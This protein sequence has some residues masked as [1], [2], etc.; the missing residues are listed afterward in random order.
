MP[1]FTQ[2]LLPA[3]LLIKAISQLQNQV[4]DKGQQIQKV[5]NHRQI[6]LPVAVVVFQF[7]A[8]ILIAVYKCVRP[9]I[10]GQVPNLPYY[11][12][13]EQVENLL[14]VARN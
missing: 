3:A 14:H 1:G 13:M 2:C 5:K 9:P 4:T 8:V 7:I 6:L 12:P 10:V 11:Q